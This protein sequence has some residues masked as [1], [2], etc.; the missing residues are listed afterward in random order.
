MRLASNKFFRIKHGVGIRH[1]PFFQGCTAMHRPLLLPPDE[2]F[3]AIEST[4]KV[5]LAKEQ[6]VGREKDD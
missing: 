4:V 2:V 1:E 3:Q 5:V 6:G